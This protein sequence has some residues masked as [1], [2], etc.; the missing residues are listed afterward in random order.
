M[1]LPL[2]LD[3]DYGEAGPLAGPDGAL[4]LERTPLHAARIEVAHPAGGGPLVVEAPWPPDLS[5]TLEALRRG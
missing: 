3:P 4:L 1:G 2:A 5:A